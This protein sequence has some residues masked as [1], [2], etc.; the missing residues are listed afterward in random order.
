MGPN[1]GE[2]AIDGP[3]F[4]STIGWDWLPAIRDRDTGI[5]Q[6]VYSLRQR[7]RPRQESPRHHRPRPAPIPTPPTSSSKPLLENVT[8]EPQKGVFH[9]TIENIT[10]QKAVDIARSRHA[11]AAASIA[12][13]TPALHMENPRLWWPN[14]YGPQNST[15]FISPL[16]PMASSP[17]PTTSPSA[18]AKSPTQSPTPTTSPSPSTASASSSAA[19][20]GASTKPSSASPASASTPKST[21]TS[22]PTS[23]LIRNWV[24]QS[25]S[26]D[27]YELCD[28]YGILIWDEF[29]QPNPS[30]GPNPTDL[31]TYMANV[32]DKILRFRNHPSIMLWC[33]RNEGFPPAG[34]RRT[35]SAT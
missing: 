8:G 18:S 11:E 30:D 9:G 14:G 12:K 29:F 13:T 25:T 3:T 21:C 4:L 28:K 32:R 7:T 2:S 26:E 33:A 16:S 5:W 17:I 10:F 35:R 6:K 20:T 22:S 1:G 31:D 34:N 23:T 24:G 15:S 19:A 27:F